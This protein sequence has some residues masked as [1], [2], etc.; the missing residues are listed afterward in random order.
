M[1]KTSIL[2]LF[3][4]LLS[5]ATPLLAD[6]PTPVALELKTD[7]GLYPAESQERGVMQVKLVPT[8]VER[9]AERPPVNL[10]IVLDRSG[11]MAGNKFNDAKQAT[12]EALQRLDR[13]DQFSLITY[14]TRAETVIAAGPIKNRRE[15]E[16]KIKELYPSG[17]TAM[18]DGLNRGAAELRKK[19]EG[20]FFDRMILISDGLANEGPSSPDDFTALGAAFEKEGI[21]VSSVGLG[22]DFSESTLS[23]LA[24]AGQGNFYFA[25]EPAQ[26]ASIFDHELGDVLS[27]VATEAVV[28]IEFAQGVEP[29]STVG[30]EGEIYGQK[31]FYRINQ[32]Y[33]GNDKFGLI[34]FKLPPGKNGEQTPLAKVTVTYLDSRAEQKRT[35]TDDIEIRYSQDLDAVAASANLDLQREVV[36][37]Y[38]ATV[39]QEAA[40]MLREG[41][42]SGA[43]SNFAKVSSFIDIL[44]Y[45]RYDATRSNVADQA[46]AAQA[47]AE[48]VE[49]D[50]M[51]RSEAI[52]V[53]ELNPFQ[54][55]NQQSVPTRGGSSGSSRR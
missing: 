32:L 54:V 20:D 24:Q 15:I 11:S 39:T 37:N 33:G 51:S 4:G 42:R 17:N 2:P 12:I 52:E 50:T 9:E 40:K 53:F 1:M 30:R 49:N 45:S 3:A 23:A 47:R 6:E 28:E 26:L 46:E 18:Y 13:N 22:V 43:A 31:V 34:E 55:T 41:D 29:V 8:A 5:A 48:Q 36:A 21:S 7:F 16:A 19:T 35:L 27:L 38:D 44:G 10:C 25:E 14:H